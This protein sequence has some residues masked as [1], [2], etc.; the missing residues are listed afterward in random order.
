MQLALLHEE[1]LLRFLADLRA[2]G[3]AYYAVRSCALRAHRPG[4]DR[5]HDHAAPA[6]E[7]RD[8][9][10]HHHRPGGE[11]MKRLLLI[12]ALLLV[13]AS[14]RRA[15]ARPPVLHA[16]AARGARRAAQGARARQAGRGGGR[17]ADHALDGY[18]TRS[19]G[20]STVWVNGEP[21]PEG[22]A[23]APR[24]G[25][26]GRVSVPVG[27]GGRRAALRPGEVLDRGTGE[28]RDV[29]G[30]GEIRIRRQAR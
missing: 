8:R 13:T 22:A 2:S 21:L 10:H 17:L 1:D 30:D 16:R 14:L 27:E 6:R 28:V 23:D 3:N 9:P 7:L 15:G 29:I 18:V 11:A 19:G 25:A 24:I 26:P 12:A 5:R 4:G 20:P